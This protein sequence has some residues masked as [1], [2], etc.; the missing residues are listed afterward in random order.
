MPII[1]H[2]FCLVSLL[3]FGTAALAPV[4]GQDIDYTDED[5]PEYIEDFGY[6]DADYD[7]PPLATA[8]E[9][10]AGSSGQGR[11]S[12]VS[13]RCKCNCIHCR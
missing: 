7:G 9:P 4:S 8:S 10:S 11:A 6:E 2:R 5:L 1:A 12:G 3:L 13:S